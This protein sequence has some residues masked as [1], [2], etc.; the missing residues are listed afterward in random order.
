MPTQGQTLDCLFVA[1]TDFFDCDSFIDV[2]G[3]LSLGG[4]ISAVVPSA[5]TDVGCSL[6]ELLSG[7]AGV[8]KDLCSRILSTS[9][10]LSSSCA[11]CLKLWTV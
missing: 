11:M 1:V 8:L 9:I 10:S 6:R 3:L 5:I 4:V 2:H 7:T